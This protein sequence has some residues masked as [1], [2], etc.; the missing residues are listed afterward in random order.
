LFPRRDAKTLRKRKE[1]KTDESQR[2]FTS[3]ASIFD[4]GSGGGRP[5][6]AGHSDDEQMFAGAEA[7]EGEAASP[8]GFGSVEI[9]IAL[10]D[11]VDGDERDAAVRGFRKEPGQLAAVEG[12]ISG[13]SRLAAEADG[14]R[15]GFFEIGAA[16]P[17]AA[18]EDGGVEVVIAAGP[19]GDLRPRGAIGI[20]E[21]PTV[22]L[23]ARDEE[24]VVGEFGHGA[25]HVWSLCDG[26]SRLRA[27]L[28]PRVRGDRQDV[29]D[30]P[31]PSRYSLPHVC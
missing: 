13:A 6:P 20:R 10:G 4:E 25:V 3:K 5:M 1:T 2:Y 29:P 27:T 26:P 21:R 8:G 9:D 28:K 30:T 16:I 12:K 17:L 31:M 11:P 22:R 23:H 14:V 24:I 18:V 19:G 15:H 7:V